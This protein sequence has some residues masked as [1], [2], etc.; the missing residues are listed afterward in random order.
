MLFCFHH[1]LERS[2]DVMEERKEMKNIYLFILVAVFAMVGQNYHSW[3]NSLPLLECSGE[4]KILERE[5]D[6]GRE[7]DR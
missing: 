5:R 6:K 7:I 4:E 2:E 1:V 3:S